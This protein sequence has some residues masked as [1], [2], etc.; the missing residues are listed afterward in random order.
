MALTRNSA[1]HGMRDGVRWCAAGEQGEAHVWICLM[2]IW[3]LPEIFEAMESAGVR[4]VVALSSTSA[5]SKRHARSEQDRLLSKALEQGE[6]QFAEWARRR[7][8]EW[9]VLR[10]TLIHGDGRD[11]NVA[12]IARWLQ[13]WRFFP[14][15]GGGRGLRQPVHVA[16]VAEA[17]LRLVRQASLPA[18]VFNLVGGETLSYRDMVSRI[19]SVQGVR[20][21]LLPV[22]RGLIRLGMRLLACLPR[23]RHLSPDLAD[24]MNADLVFDGAPLQ[25]LLGWT[26]GRFVPQ[27]VESR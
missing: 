24:R 3:G 2:P 11:R 8:V 14:L 25:A 21:V 15:V 9:V 22:P 7:C 19:A 17:C 4:R 6:Q 26:A 13:R 27:R 23:Y 16:D 12:D 20:C 5:D 18:G 1:L 10:T